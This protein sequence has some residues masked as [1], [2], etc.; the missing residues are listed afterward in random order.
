[1]IAQAVCVTSRIKRVKEQIENC[2]GAFKKQAQLVFY[3][4]V[5]CNNKPRSTH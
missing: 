5:D 1:M 2:E 3:L 4:A